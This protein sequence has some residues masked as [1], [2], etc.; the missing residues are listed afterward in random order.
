[1]DTEQLWYAVCGEQL[2]CTDTGDNGRNP[3][4]PGFRPDKRNRASHGEKDCGPV[5][6]KDIPRTGG[7]AGTA[8]CNPWDY[9]KQAGS[10]PGK[11]PKEQ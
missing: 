10:H 3:G 5:W 2:S 6:R 8:P 1:M 11:L 9:G 7:G 4:L